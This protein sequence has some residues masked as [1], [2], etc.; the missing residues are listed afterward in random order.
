MVSVFPI[1]EQHIHGI[2]EQL[3][4]KN[5]NQ[6]TEEGDTQ[7]NTFSLTH[8]PPRRVS[9][10]FLVS[11]AALVMIYSCIESNTFTYLF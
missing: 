2:V 11:Y 10:Y 4:S 7:L 9:N 1:E 6:N 5:T 3:Y 8:V